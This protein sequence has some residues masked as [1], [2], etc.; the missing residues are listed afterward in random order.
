VVDRESQVARVLEALTTVRN[1]GRSHIIMGDP[2]SDLVDKTVVEPGGAFSPG[3]WTCGLSIWVSDPNNVHSADLLPSDEIS[4]RFDR[5]R[6]PIVASSW[7]AGNATV[8]IHHATLGSE[9]AEGADFLRVTVENAV[10]DM[11]VHVVARG[12][13]P[14]GSNQFIADWSDGKLQL[15][16][17]RQLSPVT[18]PTGQTI[19]HLPAGDNVAIL[20]WVLTTDGT[21]IIEIAVEHAFEDHAGGDLVPLRRPYAKTTV[22]AGFAIAED[23]WRRAVPGSIS[24]PDPVINR[25]WEH[26][27]FHIL[28]NAEG[29]VARIGAADYPG[30]WMRDAVI[31]AHALD[32]LGRHDLARII[33]AELASTVFVGGFGAEADAP[34]QGIWALVNHAKYTRDATWLTNVFPTILERIRW[35]DRM[36]TTERPIYA[37]SFNRMPRYL[38]SPAINLVCLPAREGLIRGRMDWQFPDFYVNCWA[39]AGYRQ[40]AAAAQM[41]KKND[42]AVSWNARADELDDLIFSNLLPQFGNERDAV[43]APYPTG[44]LAAHHD[45]LARRFSEWFSINRQ[46]ADGSARGEPLWTYFEAAQAHNSVALGAIQ[47]GYQSLRRMLTESPGAAVGAHG[48]GE[49]GGNESLPFGKSPQA[50]GWLDPDHASNGN[51]PH[52]WSSAE[53]IA[54][55]RALL[56]DDTGDE[57]VIGSGTPREWLAP[58]TSFSARNLPT[59]WGPISFAVSTN[60]T[61]PTVIDVDVDVGVQWRFSP[62]KTP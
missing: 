52:G 5:D 29:G 47:D 8:T 50:R 44:A 14:A 17:G 49:P 22:E 23:R 45:A 59:K 6:P 11:L 16:G 26:S 39:V 46:N 2:F 41:L 25:A 54:A 61:D 34:G 1:H 36:R 12:E 4:F 18:A 30:L 33:C 51:M 38:D 55:V 35:I 60:D 21:I 31:Q 7:R 15:G 27:A 43:V 62:T 19:T 57:L 42:L 20:T 10:K 24:T 58:G 28:N 40:G 37:P 56:V 48:E 32:C 3:L 53:V 9:G 13:G